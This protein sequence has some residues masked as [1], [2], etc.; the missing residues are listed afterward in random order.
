MSKVI[1]VRFEEDVINILEEMEQKAKEQG[2]GGMIPNSPSGIMKEALLEYYAK[3]MDG[4]VMGAYTSMMTAALNS[5]LT[6]YFNSQTEMMAKVLKKCTVLDDDL[7]IETVM[8]RMCFA[9]LF[10]ASNMPEDEDKIRRMLSKHTSFDDILLEIAKDRTQY[11]TE[12][13]TEDK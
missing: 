8:N 2:P 7:N 6:P 9:I 11:N 4:K 1:G 3:V 5:I 12:I 10:R 13:N